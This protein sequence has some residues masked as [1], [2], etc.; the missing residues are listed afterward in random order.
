M[1]KKLI[2]IIASLFGVLLL[3]L[4][5]MSMNQ[6]LTEDMTQLVPPEL[7]D[8]INDTGDSKDIDN[9]KAGDIEIREM[10]DFVWRQPGLEFGFLERA[11]K[12]E[13]KVQILDTWVNLFSDKNIVRITADKGIIPMESDNIFQSQHMPN[14]GILEGNVTIEVYRKPDGIGFDNFKFDPKQKELVVELGRTK[15]EREFSR[16]VGEGKV[17]V[18]AHE[19]VATGEG[20]IMQYDQINKK[21]QLLDIAKMQKLSVALK[22]ENSSIQDPSKQNDSDEQKNTNQPPAAPK[23]FMTY[24]LNLSNNIRIQTDDGTFTADNLAIMADISSG[25][26][27]IQISNDATKGGDD[28]KEQGSGSVVANNSFDRSD[29]R[30]VTMTCDGSLVITSPEESF[31]S[32]NGLPRIRM[33]ATGAPVE[34]YRNGEPALKCDML[35]YE[36][37]TEGN[38][39]HLIKLV[40]KE[41]FD[42]I[43]L[44]QGN[45]RSV[46]ASKEIKYDFGTN[47]ATLLGPGK[48]KSL[49][50]D[51]IQSNIDF[52]DQIKVKFLGQPTDDELN[53]KLTSNAKVEWIECLGTVEAKI[54][55]RLISADKVRI[56]FFNA[57]AATGSNQEDDKSIPPVENMIMTGNVVMKDSQSVFNCG[58]LITR[59]RNFN[60]KSE[61]QSLWA[62]NNIKIETE[63]Y[64]I[65]VADR[66]LVNLGAAISQN[67]T[68]GTKSDS[69]QTAFSGV[70]TMFDDLNPVYVLAEGANN[71]VLFKDKEKGNIVKGS[72]IEGKLPDTS[73]GEGDEPVIT[74]LNLSN[75]GIWTIDGTSDGKLAVVEI[76][77]TTASGKSIVLNQQNGFCSIAG[78][79]NFILP[80]SGDI[81]GQQISDSISVEISWLDGIVYDTENGIIMLKQATFEFDQLASKTILQNSKLYAD[82]ADITLSVKD[83]NENNEPS[84]ELK[85]FRAY[86][87][88]VR[89]IR[90]EIDLVN[91][92]LI[93]QSQMSAS[94][95]L[96][97]AIPHARITASGGGWVE[98]IVLCKPDSVIPTEAE[99]A[100]SNGNNTES[101]AY[102]PGYYFLQFSKA[103][104]IDMETMDLEF[105]DPISIHFLPLD[106]GQK[107]IA[108]LGDS[109]ELP[110]GGR[111]LY[112]DSLKLINKE[113]DKLATMEEFSESSGNDAVAES[114]GF[115]QLGYIY[116]KG[117][118]FLELK[119]ANSEKHVFTA[120]SMLLDRYQKKFSIGGKANSPASFDNVNFEYL[121]Y[122]LQN[123]HSS[124]KMAGT[125]KI[126]AQ[127]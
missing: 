28:S 77:E 108:A 103:M 116:A 71:K 91:N 16:I 64:L 107:G 93:S 104:D 13:G 106:N 36:Q 62:S 114:V 95:I 63:K 9:I 110:A 31:V 123:G 45:L 38:N 44:A 49:V 17:R 102:N 90:N 83:I 55:E 101:E 53:I 109:I 94:Q 6:G 25:S 34:I 99:L 3:G 120:E 69:S 97:E 57:N 59:F 47:I 113:I 115:G 20:L 29:R 86:G 60:N 119:D 121:N 81:T 58:K 19:F 56:N 122:D 21:L 68:N 14:E 126:S 89:I 2:L 26:E 124:G 37:N 30:M 72:K 54:E 78:K 39:N 51:S 66:L 111:R 117:N 1:A 41:Q 61:L 127:N 22:K 42:S 100:K 32:Q 92:D 50:S 52:K 27:L 7:D 88:N 87:P 4:I 33:E 84:Y 112:C 12:T 118:I 43:Y 98:H 80:A 75:D 15:F 105:A 82:N 67:N 24:N 79:G 65:D 74:A 46:T 76:G 35:V 11:H 10:K 8:S 48:I 5:F 40:S 85:N 23:E 70:S 18:V 73:T 96:L 125:A